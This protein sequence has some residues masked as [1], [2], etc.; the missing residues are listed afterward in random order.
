FVKLGVWIRP[1]NKLVYLMPPYIISAEELT[2][3][4]TAILIVLKE[5]ENQLSH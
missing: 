5:M 1:F 2:I 3:L 4:T